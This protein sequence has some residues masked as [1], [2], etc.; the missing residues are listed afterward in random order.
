MGVLKGPHVGCDSRLD[1]VGED[2]VGT[3]PV[4]GPRLPEG[5]EEA[6]P[7]PHRPFCLGPKGLARPSRKPEYP[8]DLPR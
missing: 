7:G 3:D 6:E 8:P 1:E 4:Q 2:L 5:P